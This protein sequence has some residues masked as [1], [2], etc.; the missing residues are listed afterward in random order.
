[1]DSPTVNG[2]NEEVSQ[3]QPNIEEIIERVEK[4]IELYPF[5]ETPDFDDFESVP[6]SMEPDSVATPQ[7]TASDPTV[8]Y[9][10]VAHV[11]ANDNNS[12]HIKT[13]VNNSAQVKANDE[14][15]ETEIQSD[16]HI[17]DATS[18][19]DNDDSGNTNRNSPDCTKSSLG[20]N[21]SMNN[22]IIEISDVASMNILNICMNV[23][24][25]PTVQAHKSKPIIEVLSDVDARN[26][27][28]EVS[29]QKLET[30]QHAD[31]NKISNECSDGIVEN[32]KLN[33]NTLHEFKTNDAT[34]FTAEAAFSE[35]VFI[36]AG[37]SSHE[38]S[39]NDP[40]INSVELNKLTKSSAITFFCENLDD[41][42]GMESDSDR[43]FE[44]I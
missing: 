13:D 14:Y 11:K 2:D 4:S 28:A 36:T 7:L 1:M 16:T 5:D 30:H 25:G 12:V 41:L 24:P 15:S 17:N 10:T 42:K 9:P 31:L 43:S 3:P 39:T 23:E 22:S 27:S 8:T 6:D 35:H 21:V 32:K 44:D 18:A 33:Q 40:N 38:L 34:Q 19:F 20:T 26:L 37:N 29:V